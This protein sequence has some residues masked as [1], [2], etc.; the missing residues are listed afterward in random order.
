LGVGALEGT[1]VPDIQ[2]AIG[3]PAE[4]PSEGPEESETAGEAEE[5][6]NKR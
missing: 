1:Q 2:K 6:K 3:E 4:V 5:E